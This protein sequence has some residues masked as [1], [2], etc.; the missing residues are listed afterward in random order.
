MI[1]ATGSITDLA[2]SCSSETVSM[3]DCS[4]CGTTIRLDRPSP[5][6]PASPWICQSCGSVYFARPEQWTGRP[7]SGGCRLAPYDRVLRELNISIATQ[8]CLVGPEDLKRLVKLLAIRDHRGPER[9]H[10]KRY[11]IAAPVITVPLAPNFRIAGT[12]AVMVT[13][14]VSRSGAALVHTSTVTEPYLALDFSLTEGLEGTH[15]ILEVTRGRSLGLAI[16]IGGKFVAQIEH[17][18]SPNS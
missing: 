10:H 13:S 2:Y 1:D 15:V 12:P 18:A 4:E 11:P 17:T 5:L 8:A 14:N 6:K 16:E 9:R 7:Y 3:H